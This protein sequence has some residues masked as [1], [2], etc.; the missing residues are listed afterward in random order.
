MMN[1]KWKF[2]ESISYL[3]WQQQMCGL[4]IVD[5][6]MK[7]QR[8]SPKN[9]QFTNKTTAVAAAAVMYRAVIIVTV[10]DNKL[11]SIHRTSVHCKKEFIL[12]D[13]TKT[14]SIL[15]SCGAPQF[16]FERYLIEK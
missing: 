11:S 4:C 5:G 9:D 12:R 7:K 14:F 3:C 8:I 6:K 1:S 2:R 10:E 13:S 16:S 15:E